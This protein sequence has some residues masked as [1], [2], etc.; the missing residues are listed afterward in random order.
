M[1]EGFA[2]NVAFMCIHWGK[3]SVVHIDIF[4]VVHSYNIYTWRIL[5]TEDNKVIL[6]TKTNWLN[7][8][9]MVTNSSCKNKIKLNHIILHIE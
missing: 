1:L 4:T 8:G 2:R 6:A 7:M 3:H 5:Y 9:V